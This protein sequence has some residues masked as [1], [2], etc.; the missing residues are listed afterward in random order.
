M[1]DNEEE[2]EGEEEGG[3]DSAPE[4]QRHG[5]R[6]DFLRVT[7]RPCRQGKVS[8]KE[9]SVSEETDDEYTEV[10]GAE[11]EVGAADKD[12]TNTV[13]KILRK[14]TGNISGMCVKMFISPL[15][16]Q[17]DYLM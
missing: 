16:F 2:E 6:N 9:S 13:E 5:G 1:D 15:P 4:A 3:D 8:Y 10:Q 14:R 7:S 17:P 12:N 11:G